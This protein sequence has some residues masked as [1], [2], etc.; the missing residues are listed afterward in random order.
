MNETDRVRLQHMLDAAREVVAFIREETRESL[1]EA[2]KLVRKNYTSPRQQSAPTAPV[3]WR[4]W[5]SAID[6]LAA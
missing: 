1:D 3:C 6:A 5:R 4:N 2:L